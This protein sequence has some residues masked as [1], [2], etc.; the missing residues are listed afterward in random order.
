MTAPWREA[1]YLGVAELGPKELKQALLAA[2]TISLVFPPQ[3]VDGER[4]T[5][6]SPRLGVV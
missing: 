6:A 4:Y 5:D 2:A 1:T 3:K